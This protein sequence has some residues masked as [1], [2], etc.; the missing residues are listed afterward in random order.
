M[1]CGYLK[2][3][4]A[5]A[6]PSQPGGPPFNWRSVGCGC[7][8]RAQADE[9][10]FFN[11]FGEVNR[12]RFQ[13][14]V[15]RACVHFAQR[16]RFIRRDHAARLGAFVALLLRRDEWPVD[17]DQLA[18]LNSAFNIFESSFHA[19]LPFVSLL[20][21]ALPRHYNRPAHSSLVDGAASGGRKIDGPLAG[22]T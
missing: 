14:A 4:Y 5:G 12:T 22:S 19:H 10:S 11:C 17:D 2:T 1:R 6:A 13:P 15:D 9:Q 7:R 18:L 3:T 16:G 20:P 21:D 8:Q